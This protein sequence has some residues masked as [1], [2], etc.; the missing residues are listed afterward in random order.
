MEDARNEVIAAAGD[1]LVTRHA[2]AELESAQDAFAQAERDWRRGTD[3]QI[4]SHWAYLARQRAAIARETAKLRETEAQ[5]RKAEADRQKAVVVAR[6]S[7]EPSNPPRDASGSFVAAPTGAAR[8]AVILLENDQFLADR[9]DLDP[10]ADATIERVARLLQEDPRRSARIDGHSDD[11]GS[12]GRSL[13]LS[14]RRAESVRAALVG[15][16][17]DARRITVRALGDSYPVASNETV[18]GRERN[19]RVEIIISEAS[20]TPPA[21]GRASQ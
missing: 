8:G 6:E 20:V 5:V 18:L 9:V 19:R 15:R 4:V 12:R 11:Q 3:A 13:E 14:G 21:S 2:R 10:R 1:P 17:I 16:G 7:A